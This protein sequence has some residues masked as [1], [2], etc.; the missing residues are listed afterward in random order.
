MTMLPAPPPASP[1]PRQDGWTPDRQRRFI[2][3]LADC[4]SVHEAAARAGMSRQAAY[5]LRRNPAAV[6]FR[7]AWDA[8]LAEAWRRVEESALERAMAGE[9]EVW[10]RDGVITTRLRPCAPHLLVR[11]LERADAIRARLRAEADAI[12]AAE[13]AK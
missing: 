7:L 2:A 3:A 10:E 5:V 6:D 9:T 12:A 1:S 4:G 11:L 8:A 13:R